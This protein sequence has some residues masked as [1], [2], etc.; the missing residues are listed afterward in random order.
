MSGGTLTQRAP[1]WSGALVPAHPLRLAGVPL[2]VDLSFLLATVLTTWTLSDGVLPETDPH[3]TAL[4]YWMAGTLGALL[5]GAS[6]LIHELGHALAAYRRGL[7]VTRI[8]LSFAGGASH[9]A[10]SVRR[11][12]DAALIA[13]GGPLANL[14]TAFVAVIVH[15]AIVEIAGPGL[16]ASVSALVAVGNVALAV[17]NVLPGLPL[18]GGHALS[19]GLWKVTGRSDLA[20]RWARAIGHRLGEGAIAVAVVASA[21]GFLTLAC[22]SALFGFVLRGES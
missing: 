8:T 12:S 5:L 11:P 21:F 17:V 19:A 18:D 15:V 14:L 22:W 1:A 13:F 2:G 16:P 6:L 7:A 3:R 20:T 9:I 10:G 4:A